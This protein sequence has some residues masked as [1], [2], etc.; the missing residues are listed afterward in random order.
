[1][2]WKLNVHIVVDSM[3]ILSKFYLPKF[4]TLATASRSYRACQSWRIVWDTVAFVRHTKR[5][6]DRA[7]ASQTLLTFQLLW[8]CQRNWYRLTWSIYLHIYCTA[9]FSRW[10]FDFC[11]N[12]AICQRWGCTRNI[13]NTWHSDGS[14]LNRIR[15]PSCKQTALW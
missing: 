3:K 8:N 2:H 12:P 13:Q 14:R 15:I 10:Y 11:I 6:N 7:A 4:S 1:M 5:A 9:E